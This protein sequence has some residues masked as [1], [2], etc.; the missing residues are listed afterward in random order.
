M[1]PSSLSSLT[2]LK[3]LLSELSLTAWN[4]LLDHLPS[5][6]HLTLDNS[7]IY[8]V[9]AVSVHLRSFELAWNDEYMDQLSSCVHRMRPLDVERFILAFDSWSSCS[10]SFVID[11]LPCRAKTLVLDSHGFDQDGVI[12]KLLATRLQDLLLQSQL[13]TINLPFFDGTENEEAQQNQT[14][15][16]KAC[17]ENGLAVG[18]ERR[19]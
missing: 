13:V 14:L 12:Q 18:F 3:V 11:L 8:L 6:S 19:H 10:R 1:F 4:L 15:L 17:Q 2:S 9:D 16:I 7:N 5:L